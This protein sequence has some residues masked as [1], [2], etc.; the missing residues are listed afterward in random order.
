MGGNHWVGV[1][2]NVSV[3]STAPRVDVAAGDSVSVTVGVGVGTLASGFNT[4]IA[5]P[6]Q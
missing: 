1:G 3:G 6:I 2:S 4:S 5:M